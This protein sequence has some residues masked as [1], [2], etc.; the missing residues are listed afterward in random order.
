MELLLGHS[1]GMFDVDAIIIWCREH[2]RSFEMEEVDPS[3][4]TENSV[5][6]TKSNDRYEEGQ[7]RPRKD[8]LHIII[9]LLFVKNIL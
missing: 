9:L 8:D 2:L 5:Q 4:N 1:K 7:L 3:E 6:S